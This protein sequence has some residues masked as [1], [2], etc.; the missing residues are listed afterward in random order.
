MLAS[1]GLANKTEFPRLLGGSSGNPGL[2]T[3]A[4]AVNLS[5]LPGNPGGDRE[6]GLDERF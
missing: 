3:D 2:L 6:H 1:H 4:L 5:F